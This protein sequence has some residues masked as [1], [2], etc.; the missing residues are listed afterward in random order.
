MVKPR[1]QQAANNTRTVDHEAIA[2][3]A[4]ELSDKPYGSDV[5]TPPAED[6]VTEEEGLEKVSVTLP[7]ALRYEIDNL[8]TKRK[9][10]RLPDRTFSAIVRVAL[11]RYLQDIEK[12]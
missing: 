9:R 8:V 3:A 2:K 4:D 10:G 1:S 6:L 11:E 5:K 12:Q 7:R